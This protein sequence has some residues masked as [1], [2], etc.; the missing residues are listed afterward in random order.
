[1]FLS[2]SAARISPRL[3]LSGLSCSLWE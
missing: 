2:V 3:L 1:L